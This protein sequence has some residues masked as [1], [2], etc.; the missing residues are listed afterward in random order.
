MPIQPIKPNKPITPIHTNPFC[1]QRSG[2]STSTVSIRVT[3][4]GRSTNL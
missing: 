2:F 1:H 4:T 3:V